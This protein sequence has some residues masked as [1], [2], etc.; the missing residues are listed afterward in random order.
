MFNYNRHHSPIRMYVP[1]H[2]R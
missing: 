2:R 1:L